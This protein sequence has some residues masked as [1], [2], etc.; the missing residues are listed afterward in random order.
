MMK[1]QILILLLAL[2][3]KLSAQ[4][5]LSTSKDTIPVR[6]SLAED[7]LFHK[8]ILEGRLTDSTTL[9]RV[10]TLYADALRYKQLSKATGN[11]ELLLVTLAKLQESKNMQDSLGIPYPYYYAAVCFN[12][13]TFYLNAQN[14]KAAYYFSSLAHKYDPT[15]TNYLEYLIY[16]N[17][18]SGDPKLRKQAIKDLQHLS[19]LHPYNTTYCY[20]LIENYANTKN[21]KQAMNEIKRYI[22]IEGESLSTLQYEMF[23]LSVTGKD[24]QIIPR[25]KKYIEDNPVDRPRAEMILANHYTQNSDYDSAFPLL[26]SNLDNIKYYNLERLLN[27]YIATYFERGDTLG[28]YHLLDT[29][30]L[31]HPAGVEV[32]NYVVSVYEVT[33]DT[34]SIMRVLSRICTIDPSNEK[35]YNT[36]YMIYVARNQNDSLIAISTRGHEIFR[37]DEWAYRHIITLATDTARDKELIALCPSVVV[38]AQTP[39][40]KGVAYL[41]LGDTYMR[42][43]SIRL[44]FAAYD[45][46]LAYT[47]DNSYALNNYAYTLATS[48][49]VTTDD[50][51]RCE[52]MAARALKLDAS[53]P[54]VID[55]YAWIL[56]LRDDALSARMYYER[57]I[58]M[59]DEG[60][61]EFDAVNCW[62]IYS[63]FSKLA[64]PEA[65]TYLQ[66]AKELYR[67]H[68]D[69]VNDQQLIE[70]LSK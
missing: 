18:D 27:P 34:N 25:I 21:Y 56:Y 15:N 2:P 42:H 6:K 24:D 32:L 68:P 58:R 30:T 57:L 3:L 31:L 19:K 69:S 51:A 36:L 16:M 10:K 63:V 39:E 26:Y 53:S 8:Q 33:R 23:I 60:E 47:P 41:F 50:L 46:C 45:S 1:N 61:V 70:I 65:D 22:S 9:D 7:S 13:G 38:D 59:A 28:A 49:D 44:A 43:D 17:E 29:L 14:H 67:K 12:L 35:A 62:H 64:M 5:T 54:A 37:N 20:H 40:L 55:T 11:R 66:K 52:K 4:D 48:P